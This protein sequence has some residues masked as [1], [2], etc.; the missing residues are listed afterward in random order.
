MLGTYAYRNGFTDPRCRAT[1][2]RIGIV[3]LLVLTLAFTG[4]QWRTNRTRDL[5]E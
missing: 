2:P 5:T 4:A 3:L 1:A